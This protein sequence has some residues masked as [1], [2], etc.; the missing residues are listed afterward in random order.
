MKSLKGLSDKD[1]LNRLNNLVRQEHDV[2]LD[3]VRHL[4]EV[5][6]RGLYAG[7]AYSS[8]FEYC[9]SEFGYSDASAWRR[10]G[11]ATA[12]YRCPEALDLLEKGLVTMTALAQVAKLV[13]PDLLKVICGKSREEVEL[14]A[15][16]HGSKGATRDRTRPVMVAK[17]RTQE[18]VAGAPPA[19]GTPPALRPGDKATVESGESSLRGE[20]SLTNIKLEFEKKWKVEGLV[21][22]RV[23]QKLERCKSLLSSKYPKGV[24]YD[25]L[26][27]ELT[28]V[29]LEKTDPER[30]IERRRKRSE[31]K[32]N[33]APSATSTNHN[34]TRHIPAEV[35]DEVW[36]KYNGLCAFVGP[37]GKR[38]NST[39]SLQFDHHPIPFARGGPSTA[40]NLRLLCAKHNRY[41]AEQAFGKRHIEKYCLRE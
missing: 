15:S 41:T 24:D 10:A 4:V 26:F 5:E 17:K 20:V 40:K 33:K 11:V 12:I 32:N 19:A 25:A 16:A 27:D 8:L 35:K 31:N 6:R 3:I 13:T 2:T 22:E 1:L 14:I 36:V 30:R 21:S 38:C 29:F 28:E 9:R 18:A 23:K 39:H 34:Q 7:K 37:G